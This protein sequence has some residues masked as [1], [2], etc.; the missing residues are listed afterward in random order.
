MKTVIGIDNGTTGSI[1]IIR[2]DGFYTTFKTPVI[3]VQ[4]YTKKN[5]KVSRID[6]I[7]FKKYLNQYIF[8]FS[9]CKAYLERPFINPQPKFFKAT[10]SAIRA[11]EAMLIIL[12]DL[13]VGYEALDSRSWQHL[14]LPNGCK[15]KDLKSSS[16]DIGNRLF[17]ICKEVRH[18]D[19]DGL[20]IAEYGRKDYF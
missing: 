3:K 6:V 17:P 8:D 18:P 20:L 9:K 19:R 15:G 5:Q 7:K 12:D 1:G 14:L 13:Q 10:L 4:D 11:W 16:K 2:E